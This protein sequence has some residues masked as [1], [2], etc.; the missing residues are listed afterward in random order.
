MEI[1]SISKPFI[2]LY[3]SIMLS[4]RLLSSREQKPY[5]VS[6]KAF[7]GPDLS[8]HFILRCINLFPLDSDPRP[9]PSFPADVNAFCFGH[10]GCSWLVTDIDPV[11]YRNIGTG[12][13][14]RSSNLFR[15]S[16]W[17]EVIMW[18]YSKSQYPSIL[19]V[20]KMLSI[21]DLK[22]T[23]DLML[24]ANLQKGVPNFCYPLHETIFSNFSPERPWTHF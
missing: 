3:S 8:V 15:H 4:L 5:A 10:I 1:F 22:C 24:V 19:L 12:Q 23:V 21:S 20:N 14:H 17:S 13:G 6:C 7:P 9:Q 18:P 16:I 2:S 11:Y